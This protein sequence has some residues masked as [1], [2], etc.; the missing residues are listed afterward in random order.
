MKITE[1]FAMFGYRHQL[2]DLWEKQAQKSTR[3]KKL[4]NGLTLGF[5]KPKYLP[6]RRG[7]CATGFLHSKVAASRMAGE[8]LKRS[9]TQE[10]AHKV[11]LVV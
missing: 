11:V 7:R 3:L 6:G 1:L 9:W 10:K 8:L 2:V 4:N 5:L